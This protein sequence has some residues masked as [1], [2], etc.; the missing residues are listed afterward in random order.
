MLSRNAII[1]LASLI[2]TQAAWAFD[3]QHTA[4]AETLKSYRNEQGLVNYAKLK[5]DGKRD[6]K[7]PFLLYLNELQTVTDA[8]FKTWEPNPKKAFLINAYNALTIKLI[9]DHYPVDSIKKIGGF[10]AKPWS[11]KF[12]KLLDGK[13]QKL[14][15]LEHDILRPEYKDYRVHAALNCASIS[16]PSLRGEPYVSDRLEAQLDEQMQVWLKDPTRNVFDDKTGSLKISRI[17]DWYE[18]DF[19]NW[20][21][22]VREVIRR[23]GPPAAVQALQKKGKISYMDYNWSLNE[24]R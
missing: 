16:C 23:Y 22:G 24:S 5:E 10:L 1:L 8:E 3:Q 18:K 6:P 4:W 15:P 12:F 17:F 2:F 9:I 7:L 13:I 11:V 21:G 20:G 19:E 14:D